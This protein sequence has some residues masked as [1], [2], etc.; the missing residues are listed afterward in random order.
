MD[1]PERIYAKTHGASTDV[2]SG[3]RGL[4]GG[5][6]E[7]QRDGQTEYI[8]A[9]VSAAAIT[10]LSARVAELEQAH[11]LI[12][13]GISLEV[14][15]NLVEMFGGIQTDMTISFWKEG[16]SGPGFYCWCTEYPE[17]GSNYLGPASEQSILPLSR[18][19]LKGDNHG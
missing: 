3:Q 15:R 4:I 13:H 12:V 7:H 18:R 14:A 19:A 16:H 10:A 1:N 6:S 11:G 2:I 5:W 9:D 8:R 17:E